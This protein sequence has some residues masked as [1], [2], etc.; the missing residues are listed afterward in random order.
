MPAVKVVVFTSWSTVWHF[1]GHAAFA[2]QPGIKAH[3]TT[4]VFIGRVVTIVARTIL[5]LGVQI[6]LVDIIVVSVGSPFSD[7]ILAQWSWPSLASVVCLPGWLC[8]GRVVWDNVP[9]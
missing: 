5:F 1:H 9:L 3:H 8:G 7:Q 4:L 2:Y 6:V